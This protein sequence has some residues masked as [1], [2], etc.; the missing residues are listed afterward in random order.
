MPGTNMV[1]G[2][3]YERHTMR[4]LQDFLVLLGWCSA[5]YVGYFILRW[6]LTFL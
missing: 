3:T 2:I 6:L 5:I 4:Y 1:P